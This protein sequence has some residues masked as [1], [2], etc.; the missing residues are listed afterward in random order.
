MARRITRRGAVSGRNASVLILTVWTLFFLAALAVAVGSYVSGGLLVARQASSSAYGRAA[1][2][3]GVEH[4]A[5][6][7]HA[8]TNQWDGFAENWGAQG[9]IE[10]EGQV[11]GDSVYSIYHINSGGETNFG[12]VDEESRININKADKKLLETLF[13][14][15]GKADAIQAASLAAGV[16]DWRDTDDEVGEGGAEGGFYAGKQPGYK[17]PNDDFK[18]SYELLL[19]NG[20]TSDIY[21]KI[22]GVVTVYGAGKVNLNTA[23]RA[24]IAVLA[25]SAGADAVV[26]DGLAAK[27]EGFRTS[28]GQ[29]SEANVLSI[30]GGVKDAGLL[31]AEEESVLIGMMMSITL[32]GSCFRGISEGRKGSGFA[33]AT[34]EFVYNRNDER[35]LYWY[36]R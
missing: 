26:A 32:Q 20:M 4:I 23:E 3:A 22:Q 21:D 7:V 24:V 14:V 17:C 18:T 29:F 2:L 25:E 31:D 15:V 27:I 30:I 28:G 33:V 35:I 9:E 16:I 13:R 12:V 19:V 5:A 11:L 1:M 10:W 34:A 6:V 8:D 36:E